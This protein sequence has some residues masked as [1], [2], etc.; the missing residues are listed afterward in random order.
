MG[1][2]ISGDTGVVFPDATTQSTAVTVATPFS[3]NASAGAG[4]QLRL[5]EATANGVNYVAVKAADALAANVTFTL[6]TADGTSGQYLQTNGAGQL[7][8]ATVPATTPAGSTGQVQ[9][10][11]AGAFGA[12]AD[13]TSNQALISQGAGAA[14]TWGVPDMSGLQKLSSNLFTP[15]MAFSSA[16]SGTNNGQSYTLD[17]DRTL[18]FTIDS[19]AGI[20][21]FVYNRTTSTMGTP[22][23][24]RAGTIASVTSYQAVVISSSSVLLC[25]AITTDVQG[26]ILSISGTT[27]TVN[28]AA[29][30]TLAANINNG[31]IAV[32]QVG[33]SYVLYNGN[34]T[35][36]LGTALTVSGTTVTFGSTTVF[37]DIN[38]NFR[39]MLYSIGSSR[40]AVVYGS[41]AS[42]RIYV[43]T[44]SVS[45][46]TITSVSSSNTGASTYSSAIY[47]SCLLSSGRLALIWLNNST[48]TPHAS[49]ISFSG[50]GVATLASVQIATTPGLSTTLIS[51]IGNQVLCCLSPASTNVLLNVLTDNAGTPTVG[52]PIT[53]TAGTQPFRVKNTATGMWLYNPLALNILN[54]TISG[55]NPSIAGMFPVPISTNTSILAP[56]ASSTYDDSI[57][58]VGS[59]PQKPYGLTYLIAAS[60]GAITLPSSGTSVAAYSFNGTSMK[61]YLFQAFSFVS[62]RESD[63]TFCVIRSVS[64]NSAANVLHIMER[65]KFVG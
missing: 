37:G 39:P 24:V 46:T 62:L 33:T 25:S 47:T 42:T 5:P 50:A 12:I 57:G 14:P 40:F 28:S 22:V 17:A 10:N 23:S 21:A 35:G 2:T 65:W 11:N 8:F 59:T 52:T 18:Y 1:T 13:G 9:Y 41:A 34:L 58:V 45:G 64:N 31:G 19:T 36:A 26:V 16:V 48:N 55:N 44:Y 49:I 53:F 27:I 56:A 61:S 51:P 43:D 20:V 60:G 3:I 32:T 29:T 6:P 30:L 4:A 15:T 54:V 7:A 38:T 63:D